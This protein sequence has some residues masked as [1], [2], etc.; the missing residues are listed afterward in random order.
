[1]SPDRVQHRSREHHRCRDRSDHHRLARPGSRLCRGAACSSGA[2][3]RTASGGPTRR[4][5]P[6]RPNAR[7]ATPSRWPCN[8]TRWRSPASAG[9]V[10]SANRCSSRRRARSACG[11]ASTSPSRP[12]WRAAA[13]SGPT[14]C[15]RSA[16]AG[17]VPVDA[18]MSMACW[19]EAVE[20]DDPQRTVG[21]AAR[22]R[23]QHPL[24]RRRAGGQGLPALGGRDL[25]HDHV[26]A[27]RR[28]RRRRAG[29][30][31][32]AAAL[33][34]GPPGL[35]VRADR[36]R[37]DRVGGDVRGDRTGAGRRR[38]TGRAAGRA[39]RTGPP[40]AP[41]TRS[42]CPAPTCSGSCRRGGASWTRWRASGRAWSR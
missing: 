21:R 29:H 8:A 26:R 17:M 39:G 14:W 16:A 31:S 5:T 36:L 19:A 37:G 28:R 7:A 30:R 6:S 18:K 25:R 3:T 41:S 1:M 20:T 38:R 42:T 13:R 33:A 9:V 15:S 27:Q 12:M 32:R 34:A 40:T 11:R 4:S 23:A 24:P 10:S 2:S 35:P 22:A